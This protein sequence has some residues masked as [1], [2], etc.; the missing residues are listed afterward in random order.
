M[1]L[2]YCTEVNKKLQASGI[3]V[4]V[5]N[6]ERLPKL[7]RTLEKLKIPVMVVVGSKKVET[8]SVTVRSRFGGELGPMGIDDFIS[9]INDAILNMIFL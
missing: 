6:G 1:Q 9:S 8:Q 4:E 3:W 7:T 2:D 5:C